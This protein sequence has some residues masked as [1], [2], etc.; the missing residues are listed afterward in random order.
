MPV[1][2]T[3]DAGWQIGVSRTV[4]VPLDEAWS[5]LE[6]VES[7]LG[8]APDDVR[9]HHPHDRI[10]LGWQGTIV[11]TT[12]RPA[13]TGTTVRFHQERLPDADARARQREHWRGVLDRIFPER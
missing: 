4:P 1:G 8:E 13:A 12:V 9:S 3:K 5:R 7:W 10:R 6:Q 2:K 11:Q